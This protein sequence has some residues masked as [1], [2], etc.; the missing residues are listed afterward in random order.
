L[1]FLASITSLINESTCTCRCRVPDLEVSD[2]E[3]MD[4]LAILFHGI[5]RIW[6]SRSALRWRIIESVPSDM[7][8][9]SRGCFDLLV[10][11]PVSLQLSARVVFCLLGLYP[12]LQPIPRNSFY[13]QKYLISPSPLDHIQHFCPLEM[14]D[15]CRIAGEETSRF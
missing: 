9:F 5:V 11:D 6:A 10:M 12:F 8:R 14:L 3:D 15:I 1:A 2:D 4:C 13:C 7:D